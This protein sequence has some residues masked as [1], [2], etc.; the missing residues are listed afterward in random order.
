[1]TLSRRSGQILTLGLLCIA[2]SFSFG[3]QTAG[4]LQP[5]T[6][7][8]A[9]SDALRGDMNADG[10][11]DKTDATIILEIA[12]GYRAP[13]PDQ[14]KADPNQDGTLTVDDAMRILSAL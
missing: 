7:S 8:E 3:M 13:T 14:L 10:A 4:D 2:T 9:G 5:F 1:M 6:L 12:Q 11:V